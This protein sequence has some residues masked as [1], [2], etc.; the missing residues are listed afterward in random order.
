MREIKGRKKNRV[1]LRVHRSLIMKLEPKEMTK[2][3]T[4]FMLFGQRDNKF[5]RN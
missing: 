3:G 2:A 1:L 5:V 4:I